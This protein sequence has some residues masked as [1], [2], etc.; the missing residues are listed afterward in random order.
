MD[1]PQQHWITAGVSLLVCAAPLGFGE[2]AIALP[3]ADEIPPNPDTPPED[4]SPLVAIAAITPQAIAPQSTAPESL[5][6]T[7]SIQAAD[8]LPPAPPSPSPASLS[9][10]PFPSLESQDSLP[11]PS[12]LPSPTSP[13]LESQD[14][15]ADPPPAAPEPTPLE[16]AVTENTVLASL[17]P[18][19]PPLPS[20]HPSPPPLTLAQIQS[21]GAFE[22]TLGQV[23]SVSQLSDVQPTDWSY[24]ALQSLV[25]RYGVVAG[26]PDGTFRGDRPLTRYEFAAGLNAALD[27]LTRIIAVP[28]DDLARQED[29]EILRRL[30]AEFATELAA[31]A[32]RVDVL[33]SRTAALEAAQFSPTL[34]MGG[35]VI[36]GLAAAGG[37]DPPGQGDAQVIFTHL[38]QLQFVGSFTGRDVL[39]IGLQA[40]ESGDRGFASPD[41]LNTN[42]ALLSY[43][44]DTDNDIELS[45]LEYRFAVGDRLVITVKPVG[46]DLTSVLSPNSIFS[47]SSQG[48]ISRFAAF[49]PMLRIGSLESGFGFD[50]L[51][52]DRARLQAAFGVRDSD[53]PNN[54]IFS[55]NHRAFGVQLLTRPFNNVTTGI[56]YINA[57]DRFGYLNT[58]TGSNNADISGGFNERST[59]HALSGTLQWEVLPDL[60]FGAWGGLAITDS[61][62][63][64]AAALSTTYQFSLGFLDP[65]GRQGDLAGIL[66]GQPP[67]L[68]EGIFIQNNDPGSTLHYE[69]FYRFRVNDHLSITPGFFLVPDPGHIPENDSIFV[70]VLRTTLS[71]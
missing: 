63:S 31:I 67:R 58:F 13:S 65:F 68:R 51:I 4:H 54:G 1:R 29:L 21:A 32:S 56:A 36:F 48:A 19:P 47:S 34:Q 10:T 6:P 33:E 46:F 23:T 44:S 71:F 22:N 25:E 53:D 35:E 3:L 30:Q 37:G 43:Q 50:F 24:Q 18:S 41:V 70:A 27:S 15:R 64:D 49:N 55:S 7:I 66:I 5:T 42:M 9:S 69:A 61:L 2:Q 28:V 38:A 40:G 52:S 26:Y 60:V 11:S 14:S 20:P 45:S 16:W 8:L 39:R 62:P 59:I 12:P 17:S 57:F